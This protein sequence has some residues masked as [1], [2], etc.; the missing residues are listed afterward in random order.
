M[1]KIKDPKD[2]L[3]SIYSLANKEIKKDK[4]QS[5]LK[6]LTKKQRKWLTI[7][8]SK[9]ES[10]KAIIAVLATSFTKK[11][12]NPSQD[13]RFHKEKLKGGYSGRT[14]DTKYVTPFIKEKFR[15]FGMV[16]GSGWLTRSLEQHNPFT[17]D[18]AGRIRDTTVKD[19][20]LQILNDIEINKENPEK[21]LTALFILLLLRTQSGLKLVKNIAHLS[22]EIPI[23]LIVTGLKKLFFEPYKVSGASRLPVVAIYSIYELLMK[24][25][26]RYQNKTLLPLKTHTTADSKSKGI[27]DIEIVDKTGNYFES[28]EIKHN[29]SIDSTLINDTYD[30]FKY[31]VTNRYYLLTTA[32]PN[33]KEGD[34]T[35][36]KTVIEKIRIEH[37]CEVIVNGIIPSLKY[38]L[39]LLK[40]PAKFLERYSNNLSAEFSKTTDI[41]EEHIREWKKIVGSIGK[42]NIRS[43]QR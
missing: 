24:D 2:I 36:I 7:I 25:I 22:S 18:F 16:S 10:Q 27:G 42:I 43:N 28:V 40:E 3:E 23:D 30:K 26:H 14:F 38:Y 33:T 29:I 35:N 20:F 19:A 21:Y 15:R 5:F 11:I 6:S 39:R 12:E 4:G 13:I 32:E 34:E 37:G 9:F 17:L 1:K 41:K 8:E 31:T